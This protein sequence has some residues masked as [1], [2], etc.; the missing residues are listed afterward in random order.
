MEKEKRLFPLPEPNK[1]RGKQRSHSTRCWV[2]QG[3]GYMLKGLRYEHRTA[4]QD[5]EGCGRGHCHAGM[6]AGLSAKLKEST[7]LKATGETQLSTLLCGL[8]HSELS[9]FIKVYTSCYCCYQTYLEIQK[10]LWIA[11]GLIKKQKICKEDLGAHSSMLLL[12]KGMAI[13]KY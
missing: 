11:E 2:M 4:T 1:K 12:I 8:P 13:N 6:S 5:W 7:H 10:H 9:P 3:R